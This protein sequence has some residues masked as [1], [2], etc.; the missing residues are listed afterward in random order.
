M[1]LEWRGNEINSG[2]VQ[3]AVAGLNLSAREVLDRTLK[4]VPRDTNALANSLT[5]AQATPN[6]LESAVYTNN[7][8]AVIQHE[9]FA[10][11]RRV[12]QAKYLE[13]SAEQF[14]RGFRQLVGKTIRDH[15]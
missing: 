11:H 3:G 7:P 13:A 10:M 8:Y 4:K 1:A 2:I 6:H 5:I 15:A 9:V 12:G 14:Q